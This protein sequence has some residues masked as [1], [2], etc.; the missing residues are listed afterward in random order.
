VVKVGAVSLERLTNIIA[1][2]EALAGVGGLSYLDKGA[3]VA[4][5][6]DVGGIIDKV[7][8]VLHFYLFL[9]FLLVGGLALCQP[10]SDFLECLNSTDEAEAKGAAAVLYEAIQAGLFS[11]KV[12]NPRGLRAPNCT[13]C[14][15]VGRVYGLSQE[16]AFNVG[17][18]GDFN[19]IP[20]KVV[21][22]HTVGGMLQVFKGVGSNDCGGVG[23]GVHNYN[24]FLY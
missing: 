1:H 21:G 24:S 22:V 3:S 12:P 23:V 6:G 2:A 9:S 17:D 15:E 13:Q 10:L 5:G 19:L 7:D 8:I 4:V 20:E 16:D 11:I 14:P 18:V